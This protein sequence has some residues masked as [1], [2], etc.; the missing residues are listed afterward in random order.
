VTRHYCTYFDHNYLPRALLMIESL[1]AQRADFR[2]HVVPLSGLCARILE[3]LAL[4][5]ITVTDVAAIEARYPELLTVKAAR[6]PIEYIFTLTPFMPTYWMAVTPG[7]TEITYLDADLFFYADPELMFAHIGD[8]SIAIIPHRFSVDH[9]DDRIYGTFNV[10]WITYR[11]TDEGLRCLAEYQRD[12]IDWCYDRVEGDRYGDQRYL[13]RWPERYRD[14]AIVL[15]KGANAAFYNA[16][17]YQFG[18]RDGRFWCDDETLIFYHYHGVYLQ[19]DGSYFVQYPRI[20]GAAES[21]LIRRLYRPYLARLIAATQAL[22]ERFP[23]LDAA[24]QVLRPPRYSIP[25]PIT[26]WAHDRLTRWR[27]RGAL[28]LRARLAAGGVDELMLRFRPAV[29]ALGEVARPDRP[30]AVLDWGGGF[31]ELGWQAR[32]LKPE[33]A[34]DLHVVELPVVCDYAHGVCSDATFHDDEAVLAG[35]HDIV[36]AIAALHYAEDWR[37]VVARLARAAG[38]LL[39]LIDVPTASGAAG[40]SLWERPLADLAEAQFIG[41]IIDPAAL[42]AAIEAAGAW[43]VR[44]LPASNPQPHDLGAVRLQH[45]SF[46]C[47]RLGRA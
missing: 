26:S 43:Q 12:C 45:R 46:V 34:L 16:D 5:E 1:R 24:R 8:R 6:S 14:L 33:L 25:D 13:D 4:P 37:A 18:E 40:L 30:L 31:G 17:N 7:L 2:L 29:E 32:R 15:L 41:R 21:P 28:D 39:V 23:E 10:G 42:V 9:L 22:R 36:L 3:Q 47:R 19:N 44:E 27:L 20:H 38:T 11:A 35:T